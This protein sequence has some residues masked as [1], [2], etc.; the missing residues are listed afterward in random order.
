MIGLCY[1]HYFLDGEATVWY[2]V[3]GGSDW[4]PV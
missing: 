1:T 4:F 3:L 2:G